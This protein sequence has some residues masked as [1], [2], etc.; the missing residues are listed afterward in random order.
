[1]SHDGK[2]EYKS[3]FPIAAAMDCPVDE[4]KVQ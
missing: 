3:C 1:M 2:K 4:N